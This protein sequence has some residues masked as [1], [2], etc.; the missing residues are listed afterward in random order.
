MDGFS[1]IYGHRMGNG[2]MFSDVG[3]FK[4]N[5]FFDE[6]DSGVLRTKNGDLTIS[7]IAYAEVQADDWEIY[8]V[9]RSRKDDNVVAYIVERSE[10]VR[11]DVIS[12]RYILLSTCDGSEKNKRDVLL[13]G[14]RK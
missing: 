13:V 5:V 9:E 6:H 3:K 7:V 4:D 12:E 10:I 8:N 11:E 14:I 1:I 2:E